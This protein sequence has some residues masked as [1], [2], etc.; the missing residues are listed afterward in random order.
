MSHLDRQWIEIFRAGDYEAKGKW[1]V[2]DLDQLAESYDPA[3]PSSR[4][5]GS[6]TR[7]SKLEH[8]T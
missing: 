7:Q 4:V 8:Q 3:C 1:T 2:P 5:A 6:R